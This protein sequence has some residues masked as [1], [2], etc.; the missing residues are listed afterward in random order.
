LYYEKSKIADK[1]NPIN[2]TYDELL[3][4]TDVEVDTWID[5]LRN[6]V[7]T[8]W[9]DN[10]QPPVIGQNKNDI[11]K[12]WKKLLGYDV[13]EF[14]NKKTKVIKN[15][16]KFASGVNQFFPTMLKTKISTG[17]SSDNA[18]S[19]YDHFKEDDLRD[20][21]K[22]AM[23]R[24]L[25]KDSMY[26]FGKSVKKKEMGVPT[27]EFI[28]Y[29]NNNEKQG[30]M[31]MRMNDSVPVSSSDTEYLVLSSS[32]VIELKNKKII[33]E[34]NLRTIDNIENSY[35]LKNGDI[36]YNWYWVRLYNRQQ[37]IFPTAL[38]IFRLG[39]GQPAVNFPPLTAKFLYEYFTEHIED[40]D[41][42]VYDP[43][44]GWGGRILG[45]MCS[46]RRLHYIGT[47]PNPDNVGRYEN[48]AEFY[49]THCFQ[50]NPF[51]G[52]SN[53]NTYSVFTNGSEDI[54]NNSEFRKHEGQVDFVFTSP[55]YFNREQYSQD[56]NQSFKKFSAYDDWRDNFLKPTLTTAYKMLKDDRYICWNI[57]DIK[58]GSDKFIPLEQDS[59]DIVESLGG[60]YIDTYK[61]LM[62]RMIGIDASSVK[63]SVKVGKDYFKFEPILIFKKG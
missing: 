9:E 25:Y 43:S 55:P 1:D 27:E 54:Y 26:S 45:A 29:F 18:T 17:V 35:K 42:T 46:D 44:S 22:K 20:K 13:K 31:I 16:N 39:L 61:M 56:E 59:I 7:I 49:N 40:E 14:F 8:Q 24:G 36:R 28:E 53:P 58:V 10:A 47:D 3:H 21:F 23:L 4:K 38:Q 34:Q 48:V 15:F 30:I 52:R 60:K 63:N 12:N 5:E 6:Y 32:E 33:T 50:S 11:I 19:I 57:A 2:I 51:W 62:T 41:I 37:R